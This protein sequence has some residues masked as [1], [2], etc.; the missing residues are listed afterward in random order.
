M[1]KSQPSLCDFNG[2]AAAVVA[3]AAVAAAVELVAAAAA[4]AISW[5]KCANPKNYLNGQP[6]GQMFMRSKCGLHSKFSKAST[7]ACAMWNG[8]MAVDPFYIVHARGANCAQ[9]AALLQQHWW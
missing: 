8:S 7:R 1:R 9:F 3:A 4:A 2:L 5:S 6:P